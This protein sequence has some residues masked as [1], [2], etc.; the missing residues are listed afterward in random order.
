M[1]RLRPLPNRSGSAETEPGCRSAIRNACL[2]LTQPVRIHMD[3]LSQD[4]L[5]RAFEEEE[6]LTDDVPVAKA[7][8][9][10]D[11]PPLPP[12]EG[13]R[14]PPAKWRLTTGSRVCRAG[15]ADCARILS[16]V[17]PRYS[18]FRPPR[19]SPSPRRCRPASHRH[20]HFLSRRERRAISR[21]RIFVFSFRCSEGRAA[22]RGQ[23]FAFCP[24]GEMA[25]T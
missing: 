5:R 11:W 25:K 10:H 15:D 20:R 14:Q 16:Y 12:G 9:V 21:S 6:L 13:C 17:F 3:P 4:R 24:G 22:P 8:H 1:T 2:Q 18:R 23:V 19:R 7:V